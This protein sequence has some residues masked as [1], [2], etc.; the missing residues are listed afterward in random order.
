MNI[1]AIWNHI[2]NV[3]A[4]TEADHPIGRLIAITGWHLLL[5]LRRTAHCTVHA[6]EYDQ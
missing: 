4:N 1:S 3:D 5:D 2:A 6:V